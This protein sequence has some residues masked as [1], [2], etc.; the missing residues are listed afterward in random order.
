MSGAVLEI[1]KKV[2][3]ILT[4]ESRITK[5]LSEE[6]KINQFLDSILDF[7]ESMRK[8]TGKL[9][10]MDELLC[11]ITWIE[12][13]MSDEDEKMLKKL[14]DKIDRFH[15]KGIRFYVNIRQIFWKHSIA[16]E[17]IRDFKDAL[18]DLEEST[19]ELRQILFEIR[20]DDDFMN[21]L[22]KIA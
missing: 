4:S 9:R 19:L 7:K 1:N 22:R 3:R 16:R 15:Q 13:Q 20:K 14:F 17:E 8:R 11:E 6:E 12:Q 2:S 5:E 21:D 10:Y 18:D